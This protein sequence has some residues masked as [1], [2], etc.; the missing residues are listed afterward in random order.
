MLKSSAALLEAFRRSS[1]DSDSKK[2]VING[3]EEDDHIGTDS[4]I[5]SQDLVGLAPET[6]SFDRTM[7]E[8]AE[9]QSRI[10]AA[11]LENAHIDQLMEKW[12]SALRVIDF[13]E[14][15]R[16]RGV[17]SGIHCSATGF[18]LHVDAE[19]DVVPSSPACE[20]KGCK[21]FIRVKI[22]FDN[23][24][25]QSW[26]S[27]KQFYLNIDLGID[28]RVETIVW[29]VRK[30][31]ITVDIP[32]QKENCSNFK[33]IITYRMKP[34]YS[35][36]DLTLLNQTAIPEASV[37]AKSFDIN[38]LYFIR[39]RIT[40][41]QNEN[42]SQYFNLRQF[43]QES[44]NDI[45]TWDDD[46]DLSISM[47][48]NIIVL[49]VADK[50]AVNSD[51]IMLNEY[52]KLLPRLFIYSE[53]CKSQFKLCLKSAEKAEFYVGN[54]DSTSTVEIERCMKYVALFQKF[55]IYILPVKMTICTS[56]DVISPLTRS[57]EQCIEQREPRPRLKLDSDLDSVQ[58]YES[59]E[60]KLAQEIKAHASQ[61][62]KE[63]HESI[64]VLKV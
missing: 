19:A 38:L 50:N 33:L 31:S 43:N 28:Q 4:P 12:F 6:E 27:R 56:D 45:D 48:R 61:C 54:A 10:D 11:K 5:S 49:I 32:V 14:Q 59:P 21:L 36:Q 51:R 18:N 25:V 37:M 23:D 20:P 9:L 57:I 2:Q 30:R 17:Q 8:I 22:S 16:L 39:P 53:P 46:M 64:H 24:L 63:P 1:G 60:F 40:P 44:Q 52:R 13:V 42:Q 58:T 7:D 47:K 3:I 35:T 41:P 26:L 29:P 15:G 34:D 55:N 62:I